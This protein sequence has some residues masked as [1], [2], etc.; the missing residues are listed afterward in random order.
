MKLNPEHPVTQ[1][2]DDVW[3]KV[4][5]MLMVR[6]GLTEF[7]ITPEAAVRLA[8]E[9]DGKTVVADARGGRLVIRLLS[10]EEALR[11]AGVPTGGR[12]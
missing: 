3:H 10:T 4:V 7:E 1:A 6:Y 5:A 8:H 12:A 9:I 2:M 11:L